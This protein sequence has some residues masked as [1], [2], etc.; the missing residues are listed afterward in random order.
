MAHPDWALKHKTKGTELRNIRDKYYLYKITS[1]WD[2][3]LKKTKKITLGQ[4]G[5]I[6]EEHGLIP[7]GEK[8][9]GKIP[10][11]VSIFKNPR[12]EPKTEGFLDHFGQIDDPRSEKNQL[13]TVAEILFVTFAAMICGANGWQ[14][15]EDYGKG[16]LSYLRE[17]LDYNN[18][19]PSD[20]TIRRFFR[21]IDPEQFEEL[22]KKWVETIAKKS[23]VKVIAID[24]KT[25]RHSFDDMGR[26]LHM[27]SAFATECRIVLGQEKVFDKTNEIVAIPEM[28]QWLDVAGHIV[29]IDA[30]G[31]QFAIA[32]TIV[33][34]GGNY[35]FALKGNQGSLAEDVRL[36]FEDKNN[37]DKYSL[38]TDYDKAHGRIETRECTVSDNISWLTNLH[39]RW[40]S[41]KSII[42]IKSTRDMG[43][44]INTETRYYI[45]SLE[46]K[47]DKMVHNIRS[48]WA[49]E[50]SLHWVLDMS[51]GD[52]AS[53]IRKGNAPHTMA[54]VRHVAANSLQLTKA[55]MPKPERESIVRLR[56]KC[57]WDQTILDL[58]LSRKNIMR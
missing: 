49:I 57:N 15:I 5:V 21:N 25:S 6:T 58:A 52:D 51:F 13:Y 19:A 14:D 29:T 24:G 48:H 47:A 41:I 33:Q 9:R 54:I 44:N 27:L 31:C 18:G 17:Y 53:R 42:M 36:Y 55:L 10:E 11:G 39:P 20:D 23:D 56:K 50:N 8:K 46:E 34:K 30:M 4:I 22:F 1:K 16:R 37:P 26:P 28:L 45:S 12:K 2:K 38:H 35:I 32:D 40:Q 3:E 7:T 43:K